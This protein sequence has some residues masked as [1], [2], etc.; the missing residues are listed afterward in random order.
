MHNIFLK[1]FTI[2][3]IHFYSKLSFINLETVC[4]NGGTGRRTILRGWRRVG[5]RVRVPLPAQ[6]E[7]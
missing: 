3:L 5:V 7:R 1:I 4:G 2:V 6:Y